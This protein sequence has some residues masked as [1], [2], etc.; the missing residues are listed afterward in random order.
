MKQGK[1]YF[2]KQTPKTRTQIAG[3]GS[4]VSGANP[5]NPSGQETRHLSKHYNLL[6]LGKTHLEVKMLGFSLRS[7]PN[8]LLVLSGRLT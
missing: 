4:A 7:E 8:L 1:G 3:R 2:I 6:Y 5:M